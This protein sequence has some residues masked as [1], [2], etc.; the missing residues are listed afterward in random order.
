MYKSEHKISENIF[1]LEITPDKLN[2]L[3]AIKDFSPPPGEIALQLKQLLARRQ[4][5]FGFQLENIKRLIKERNP[6][7]KLP[8]AKGKS[9]FPGRESRWEFV[10]NFKK[11]YPPPIDENK[12]LSLREDGLVGFVR[13][14]DVIARYQPGE[15]SR[16]GTD[17][18]GKP[19]PVKPFTPK[20]VK[21]GPNIQFDATVRGA[22]AGCDGFVRVKEDGT[23]YLEPVVLLEQADPRVGELTTPQTVVVLQDVRFGA[24]IIS[25]KDVWVQ[26]VVEDAY[27]KAGGNIVVLGGVMGSGKGK[28]IAGNNIYIYSGRYQKLYAEKDIYFEEE[29]VGCEVSSRRKIISHFGRMV[30]GKAVAT[31]RIYIKSVGSSEGIQTILEVGVDETLDQRIQKAN[32][33]LNGYLDK[34]VTIK[35]EIYDLVLKQLDAGLTP[36]EEKHLKLLQHQNEIIPGKLEQIRSE[37]ARLDEEKKELVKAD[38]VIPGDLYDGVWISVREEQYE[39]KKN[40][41]LRRFYN[42]GGKIRMEVLRKD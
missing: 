7:L 31:R 6:N 20:K 24:R 33:I 32:E 27:V 23:I 18:F 13:E 17:V 36:D 37:I 19:I 4:I 9:P 2:V 3:V 29:L 38:V 16:P 34:V 28:L 39:V 15:P 1:D 42:V 8:V 14:G 11:N 10:V 12:P 35:Q 25:E 22:K 40:M 41:R 26:G 5:K 21:V 30:G